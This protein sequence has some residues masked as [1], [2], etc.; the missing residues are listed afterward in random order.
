ME[1]A[2]LVIVGAGIFGLATAR[3]FCEAHPEANVVILEAADSAGGT[4]AKHRLYPGLKTN[5]ILGTY[6]FPDFPMTSSEFGVAPWQHIPG[7]NLH[8]Y[9]AKFVEHY[10]IGRRIRFNSKVN[11]VEQGG[12]KEW[13]LS[14]EEK[15]VEGTAKLMAKSLVI[16]TGMTGNPNVPE[17]PGCAD[18]GAPLFHAKDFLQH[19][20]LLKTAKHVVVY[21]GAKSAWDGVYA[22]ASSGVS[23]DW[24]IRDSGKGPTWMASPFVSPFRIWIEKLVFTRILTWLTPCVWGAYDGYEAIKSFLHTSVLGRWIVSSF[25]QGISNDTLA[26][27]DYDSHPETAKLKPWSDG[28]WAGTSL[29]MLNYPTDF[30]EHVRNGQVKV[31]HAEITHLTPGT[32]HL[33]SG[34][35]IPTDA[36]HCSTGWKHQPPINVSPASLAKDLGL[37]HAFTET[38][39]LA[40]AADEEIFRHFPALK[41]QPDVFPKNK[42]KRHRPV[43]EEV[44][45]S[46]YRLFRFM[47]PPKYIHQRNF[48]VAGAMLSFGQPISA[49]TQGLWITSY[50]DG[51]LRVPESLEEVEYSAELFMRYSHWRTPAG[52]GRRHGDMIF[53]SMPYWDLLLQDLGVQYKRKSSW[54]QE[55]FM[56]YGVSDYKG[57][58]TEWITL[59]KKGKLRGGCGSAFLEG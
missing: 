22:Y 34:E 45:L 58:V 39:P 24:V 51:T 25:Y 29:S 30:F 55:I 16:A 46:P 44:S 59:K 42:S 10:D 28:F 32:V 2:D 41:D 49:Q 19:D 27:N 40:C 54:L 48:A 36:L 12:N 13:I 3:A 35:A 37:P 38:S 33:S 7:S 5:N 6:E 18:F 43:S 4:W 8:D 31:H 56:P 17:I 50:L 57:L 47:V 23:V 1:A 14:I 21:G 11:V 26:M 20:S 9:I 15:G 52:C 53:E